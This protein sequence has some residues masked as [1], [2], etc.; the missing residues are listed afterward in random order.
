MFKNVTLMLALV[1]VQLGPASADEAA[2]ERGST[3]F[4]KQCSSCHKVNETG[5]AVGP[6]LQGVVGRAAGTTEGFRYSAAMS[7]SGI[8]WTTENLDSFLEKP[9]A[10]MKGTRMSTSVRDEQKRQDII[11]FLASLSQE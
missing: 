4:K 7:G 5:K 1:T 8:T 6:I 10:L 9:S 3:L 11:A 2:I